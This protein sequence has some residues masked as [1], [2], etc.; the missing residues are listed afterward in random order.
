[1]SC[2]LEQSLKKCGLASWFP[3]SFFSRGVVKEIVNDTVEPIDEGEEGVL[4][5]NPAC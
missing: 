1:M 3:Y 4:R 5:L 2:S